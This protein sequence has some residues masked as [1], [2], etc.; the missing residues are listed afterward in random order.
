[1]TPPDPTLDRFNSLLKQGEAV[2]V[3]TETEV[4]RSW[5]GRGE[6]RYYDREKVDSAA[7]LE[8][9]TAC[10]AF[11][12]DLLPV[13]SPHSDVLE[14]FKNYIPG[15]GNRDGLLARLRAL[16]DLYADGHLRRADV[17]PTRPKALDTVRLLCTGFHRFAQAITTRR[18]AKR[19]PYKVSDEYDVQDLMFALLRLYFDDVRPEDPASWCAGASS[20][21]DF[22][23]DDHA[24]LIELKMT[25][26]GYAD[27]ELGKDLLV[28]IGRYR[29]HPKCKTIVILVY[30]R[31]G[32]LTNAAGLIKDLS[33][34]KDGLAV[35]TII[36]PR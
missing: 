20:R 30:D 24:I 14:R 19:R 11:L 28:D 25:R 10:V 7:F 21:V 34:T 8:W 6:P 27:R 13:V 36:V 18:Y 22:V 26:E 2:S 1:M 5:I 32:L 15:G 23:L 9:Q 33:G 12:S 31:A 35:E 29:S 16:R 3:R 4:R 17:V